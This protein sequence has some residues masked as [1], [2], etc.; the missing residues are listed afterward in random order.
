MKKIKNHKLKV[1]FQGLKKLY[2]FKKISLLKKGEEGH[3]NH[4]MTLLIVRAHKVLANLDIQKKNNIIILLI[5]TN[6]I[7]MKQKKCQKNKK[8]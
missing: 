8:Y 7:N 3:L 5:K 2:P 1:D 4:Q 6:K